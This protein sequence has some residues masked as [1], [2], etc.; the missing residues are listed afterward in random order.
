MEYK[1]FYP[2]PLCEIADPENDNIDVCVTTPDGAVCTIVFITPKNLSRMM[3]AGGE[4]FIDPAFR[5]V[6]VRRIDRDS[7][8]AA[9]KVIAA[10]PK[11]LSY[12]GSD[13]T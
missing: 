5:F 11:L 10:D 12:Y 3:E 2:T 8:E 4:A 7:V 1:V 13:Q 6:T 9:L